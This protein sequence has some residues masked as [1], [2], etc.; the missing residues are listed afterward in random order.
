LRKLKA[1]GH[2]ALIFT[3]MTKMLDVF[4]VF[5]NLHGH[6]YLRLDGA[7]KV[8][9]RQQ[10]M[11]WF[12]SDPKVFLFILS[13]RAG[14]LGV[15][16]V[17]ADTVIFYDS[18]WNPAM[19]QQ[20]QDRCHRIGQ[21]REVHIYHMISHHTIE[22]NIFKKQKQK[23]NLQK[24]VIKQGNF[25]TEFFQQVDL[26][27]LIRDQNE[28]AKLKPENLK[29]E[30][31]L[32]S[33]LTQA[34]ELEDADATKLVLE[35][36]RQILNEFSDDEP[37]NKPNQTVTKKE[38]PVVVIADHP[39]QRENRRKAI[40]EDQ[41]QKENHRKTQ[42]LYKKL[43]GKADWEDVLTAIQRYALRFLQHTDP[44]VDA[45]AIISQHKT[46]AVNEQK[47]EMSH[48][49]GVIP[50]TESDEDDDRL[51]YAK[52]TTD[53]VKTQRH[54]ETVEPSPSKLK[55]TQND[56]LDLSEFLPNK[57]QRKNIQ[58]DDEEVD[59]L[60]EDP[61]STDY[62]DEGSYNSSDEEDSLSN[63]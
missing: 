62:E 22:E 34:E 47:W 5:L 60:L 38:Q 9:K 10:M 3:Q 23:K 31:D 20:A 43:V 42:Q 15:N 6:T 44:V 1:E 18:D 58:P 35:E 36:Q 48:Q 4:E 52:F 55:R 33:I 8:E 2:R 40:E 7:T 26:Q 51:I 53:A 46:L 63:G 16:L 59:D 25:T 54:Y 45:Q 11:E 29:E 41:R 57:K 37:S 50:Q 32:I 30:K 13:T 28:A 24:A 61:D 27:S 39:R 21:T 49:K 56:A 17:G 12:N 14:G 19:D